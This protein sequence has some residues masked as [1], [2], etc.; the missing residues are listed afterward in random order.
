VA[1]KNKHNL[2]NTTLTPPFPSETFSKNELYPDIPQLF[3]DNIYGDVKPIKDQIFLS[4]RSI[5]PPYFPSAS[6]YEH[7]SNEAQVVASKAWKR[8]VKVKQLLKGLWTVDDKNGENGENGENNNKMNENEQNNP[9]LPPKKLP[10]LD[11]NNRTDPD[12]I[13]F[14]QTITLTAKLLQDHIGLTLFGFDVVQN[15]Y[16]RALTIIDVNY[17]PAYTAVKNFPTRVALEILKKNKI[18]QAK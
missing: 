5:L 17:F 8:H 10:L 9:K 4:K 18:E 12:T 3:P 2:Q 13:A 7:A 15:Y 16:T 6:T 14:R 11:L 1:K